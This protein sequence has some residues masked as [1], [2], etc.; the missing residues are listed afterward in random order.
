DKQKISNIRQHGNEVILQQK[1]E[2]ELMNR[3][4]ELK[5]L[6]AQLTPPFIF[7]SMNAIQYFASINDKKGT[8]DY[9]SGFSRFLRQLLN[10]ASSLSNSV[11]NEADI[12]RQY[13]QLEKQRFLDKFDF[14]IT[15]EESEELRKATI[16]A[17]LVQSF[18]EEALYH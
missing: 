4:L 7:N 11:L 8:L 2:I 13:L 12:L 1:K 14:R 5:I 18:A 6:Q 9:I 15:T 10:T 3:K 16:P 17:L